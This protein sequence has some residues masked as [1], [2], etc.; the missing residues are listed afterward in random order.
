MLRSWKAPS[1]HD[2]SEPYIVSAEIDY[3]NPHFAVDLKSAVSWGQFYNRWEIDSHAN[4][5]MNLSSGTTAMGVSSTRKSGWP[6]PAT[7][8]DV[9]AGAASAPKYSFRT[10]WMIGKCARSVK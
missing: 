4:G 5:S 9:L 1:R 2:R 3:G 6:R 7:M 10:A 8:T